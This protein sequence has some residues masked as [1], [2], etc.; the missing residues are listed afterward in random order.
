MVIYKINRAIAPREPMTILTYTEATAS[1]RGRQVMTFHEICRMVESLVW[2]GL[3]E[4]T[5]AALVR[6]AM[7]A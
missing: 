2:L 5:I 6:A 1:Q 4:Q 7:E 3:D